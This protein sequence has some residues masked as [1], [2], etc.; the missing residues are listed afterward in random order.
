MRLMSDDDGRSVDDFDDDDREQKRRFE[1]AV[2][3]VLRRVIERAVVS[4]FE[5]LTEAPE[6]IR[7]LVSDLR[8]PKDAVHFLYGQVD[9]TKK[10]IYRIVAKEIRDVLENL[11]F[12]D[13]IADVLTKLSFEINTT[14]RFVPND[15][16]SL[17]GKADDDEN[18]E[19]G[20]GEKDGAKAKRPSKIPRPEV[21]SRVVMMAV[22]KLDPRNKEG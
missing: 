2:P 20:G 21:V 13:E 8:V 11:N 1:R 3:D 6:N 16:T 10:G 22:D 14:I 12:S 19:G 4:S 18:E 5:K 9:D 15:G 17:D 7:D